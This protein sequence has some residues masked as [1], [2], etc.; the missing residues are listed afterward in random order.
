MRNLNKSWGDFQESVGHV[1]V[2]GGKAGSLLDVLTGILKALTDRVNE[3]EH[4]PGVGHEG[5]RL[6]GRRGAAFRGGHQ[7]RQ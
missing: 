2:D 3:N 6:R 1:L 7:P 4:S 5:A